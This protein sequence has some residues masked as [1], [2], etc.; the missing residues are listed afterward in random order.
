MNSNH[1]YYNSIIQNLVLKEELE[2]DGVSFPACETLK[3]TK[4][5]VIPFWDEQIYPKIKN[6]E[7]ILIVA[8]GTVLRSLIMH[9]EGKRVYF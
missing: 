8:H 3:T 4:E 2:K 5:R 6:G 1:K 9:L 7:K